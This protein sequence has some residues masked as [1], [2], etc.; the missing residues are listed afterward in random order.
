MRRAKLFEN[1]L[2]YLLF[3]IVLAAV[4][5]LPSL[6]VSDIPDMSSA[7][8][9]YLYNVE[10]NKVMAQKNAD[11]SVYPASTVKIMTGIVA[12]EN[13]SGR[14]SETITVT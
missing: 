5:V 2:L 13:L 7:K 14:L 9:V 8:A 3:L 4:M 6:A 10:Q 12:I 1:T 11:I